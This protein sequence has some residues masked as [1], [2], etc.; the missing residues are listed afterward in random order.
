MG[1]ASMR[2]FDSFGVDAR[3]IHRLP[4]QDDGAVHA[5][6]NG[7][8]Q[9]YERGPEI[10]QLFG[11]AYSCPSAVSLVAAP[12]VRLISDSRRLPGC[13][14]WEHHLPEGTLTDCAPRAIRCFQRRHALSS[15]V[16]FELDVH[17][18]RSED[19][20][21]LFPGCL[22]YLV[23]LPATAAIY[24]DYPLNLHAHLILCFQGAGAPESGPVLRLN[25]VGRMLVAAGETLPESVE[26]MR[27]AL[28]KSPEELER[29]AAAE[30][31][32]FSVRRLARQATLR[33]HPLS[34]RALEAAEGAAFLIRAQQSASGGI[35]AGHNYHLAY[36]RDMYGDF[37]GLLA[38]G[39]VEEARAILDF[40]RRVFQRHGAIHNAQAMGA[41]SA[42]HVH[43]N[44]RVEI[45]GYLIIQALQYLEKTGDRDFFEALTPMLDW[46]MEAQI[47]ELHR[48][49]LPFNGDE[50]YIAGHIL[51]RTLMNHGSFE[52]TLLMLA[53]ARY[54]DERPEAPWAGEAREKLNDA[55]AVFGRNFRRG[56]AY[57]ANSLKR[58]EG[59]EEPA[60]RHGACLGCGAFRWLVR[61][62][63]GVYHCPACLSR[64]AEVPQPLRTEFLLRSTTLMA[65]YVHSD[66]LSESFIASEVAK[67]LSEYRVAGRLPSL[68]E[69]NRSVGY[70][71]G[72]LLYA[73]AACNLPADDLLKHT[74][75]IRDETGAWCEYYEGDLPRQTRCR[76]WET[77]INIEGILRY[78]A[79]GPIVNAKCAGRN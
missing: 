36:V 70:D 13:N 66:L 32:A 68:P 61:S 55:R 52:A 29:L 41:D 25:G 27:S 26:Q 65:P 51:P 59:L 9:V 4:Y 75:D 38:L 5:L 12:G 64:G 11:P 14:L 69:G 78:L 73:A 60:F 22:A 19:V 31:E 56:D 30:D 71:F 20:S 23:T 67:S 28:S 39:C 17:D 35:Q 40:Y 2:H 43:E 10:L 7:T 63:E 50:T 33:D 3:R 79:G 54:L 44:D 18:F 34:E 72:L 53:G 16:L 15:P 57:A 49:M 48:G 24:N 62:G 1:E 21:P 42:F 8:L 76:P 74:L 46:A 77:A 37:R 6:G 58:M 47:A 45:T